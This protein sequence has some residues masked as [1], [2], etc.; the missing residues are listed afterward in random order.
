MPDGW[1][2]GTVPSENC[3]RKLDLQGLGRP[4]ATAPQQPVTFLEHGS[5]H[6]PP[7]LK[8][9]CSLLTSP[10][11][12]TPSPPSPS[13]AHTKTVSR[14]LPLPAPLAFPILLPQPRGRLPERSSLPPFCSSLPPLSSSPHCSNCKPQLFDQVS[15]DQDSAASLVEQKLRESKV[16]ISLVQRRFHRAK[17]SAWHTDG[18]Y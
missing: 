8:I 3:A 11:S 1:E 12:L 5:S 16:H 7:L 18:S 4:P 13:L 10:S 17:H 9:L 14:L 2:W 6:V 15:D